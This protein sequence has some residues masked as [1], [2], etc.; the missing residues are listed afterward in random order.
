MTSSKELVPQGSSLPPLIL[1]YGI[2]VLLFIGA[3]LILSVGL[4]CFF[5]VQQNEA[6][7]VTRYGSLISSKPVGP[8]F[9]FK[10]PFIDEVHTIRMSIDKIAIDKVKV[11]TTDNQFV[12]VDLNL[13]YRVYDPFKAMFQVGSMG[14][15]GVIDKVIPFAQ[16]RALDVFGQVNALQIVDQKQ[17]LE[18]EILRATQERAIDL[19]GEKIE[20]VQI[21][22]IEYSPGFESNIEKMVQTRNEQISAQNILIVRQTEAKQAVAIAQGQADSAAATADGNKRVAIA[23]AEGEKTRITLTAEG[24]AAQTRLQADAA[25]YSRKVTSEAE[26]NAQR[27][28]V[29]AVGTAESEVIAAKVKSAGSVDSYASILR[30]EA[31]KKW[32]GSVPR[33][34]LGATASDKGGVQPVLVL[35]QT[36]PK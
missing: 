27:L 3:L 25:A 31:S 7:G 17:A 12:E 1:R 30:A 24:Q 13:T 16:S 14:N 5:T 21:T 33:V 22:H 10:V 35:P 18:A 28:I 6:A 36:D 26:A 20:D 15:G 4:S 8:G 29:T 34:Q 19:F 11:K 9:H 32:D 23:T 2:W